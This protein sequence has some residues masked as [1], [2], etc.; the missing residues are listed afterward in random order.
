MS[1]EDHMTRIAESLD[2]E[3]RSD[4]IAVFQVIADLQHVG[5]PE[6]ARNTALEAIAS[7]AATM[8]E[9]E[10]DETED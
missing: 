8:D 6:A 9:A 7:I 4:L 10:D 1:I 5:N 2:D 3:L